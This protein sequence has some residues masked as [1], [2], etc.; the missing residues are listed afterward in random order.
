[1]TTINEKPYRE[2]RCYNCRKLFGYEYVF[3]GRLA[4]SCPRCSEL[5]E[6]NF[7]HTKTAENTAIVENEFTLK[8]GEIK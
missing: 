8:G 4:F 2:L 3:A 7:K 5:N 1:M 6:F